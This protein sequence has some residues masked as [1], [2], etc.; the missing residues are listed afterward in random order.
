MKFV[1]NKKQ[2]V[3]ISFLTENSAKQIYS[4]KKKKFNQEDFLTLNVSNYLQ[5]DSILSIIDASQKK[6]IILNIEIYQVEALQ[7][8]KMNPVSNLI[9]IFIHKV[10]DLNQNEELTLKIPEK[11]PYDIV[12]INI[13]SSNF[14]IKIFEQLKKLFKEESLVKNLRNIKINFKN[15]DQAWNFINSCLKYLKEINSISLNLKN[16]KFSRIFF[17]EFTDMLSNFIMLKEIKL[18]LSNNLNLFHLGKETTYSL[19]LNKIEKLKKISIKFKEIPCNMIMNTSLIYLLTLNSSTLEILKLNFNNT[20]FLDQ[21]LHCLVT[22]L[23]KLRKLKTF[24]LSLM[25]NSLGSNGAK[26]LAQ[27]FFNLSQL[28]KLSLNLNSNTFDTTAASFLISSVKTLKN[29]KFLSLDFGRNRSL[30]STFVIRISELNSCLSKNLKFLKIDLSNLEMNPLALK[31]L[32]ISFK[33]LKNLKKLIINLKENRFLED[34]SFSPQNKEK[35]IYQGKSKNSSIINELQENSLLSSSEDEHYNE[36]N[37]KLSSIQK[38]KKNSIFATISATTKNLSYKN[39][40]FKESPTKVQKRVQR[41]QKSDDINHYF[42]KYKI[43]KNLYYFQLDISKNKCDTQG[44]EILT[45]IFEFKFF[46]NLKKLELFLSHNKLNSHNSD[47]FFYELEQL[48]NLNHLNLNLKHNRLQNRGCI[49][50]S[51][52]ISKLTNLTY[53]NLNLKN[54]GISKDGFTTLFSSLAE[55][56]FL[57]FLKINL[58]HN[59]ISKEAVEG[60]SKTFQNLTCLKFFIFYLHFNVLENEGLQTLGRSLS[61]LSS[62]L[63]HLDLNFN[64]NSSEEYDFSKIIV[65]MMHFIDLKYFSLNMND[66]K[67][68][69]IKDFN[70]LKEF[71]NKILK[72]ITVLIL[73]LSKTDAKNEFLNSFFSSLSVTPTKLKRLVLHFNFTSINFDNKFLERFKNI[74][75]ENLQSLSLDFSGCFELN[76]EFGLD[77]ISKILIQTKILE[78]LQILLKGNTFSSESFLFFTL[79]LSNLKYLRILNLDF[80]ASNLTYDSIKKLAKCFE[81]LCNLNEICLDFEDNELK[82]LRSLEEIL[83]SL[84]NCASNL[85]KLKINMNNTFLNHNDQT[86]INF[87]SRLNDL[88]YVKILY[89]DLGVNNLLLDKFFGLLKI[90]SLKLAFLQHFYLNLELNSFGKNQSFIKN[91]EMFKIISDNSPFI[92]YLNIHLNFNE[93]SANK[94]IISEDHTEFLG[95]YPQ[96]NKIKQKSLLK[97]HRRDSLEYNSRRIKM[98]NINNRKIDMTDSENSDNEINSM[99]VDENFQDKLKKEFDVFKSNPMDGKKSLRKFFRTHFFECKRRKNPRKNFSLLLFNSK[100][101]GIALQ[102]CHIK[103]PNIDDIYQTIRNLKPLAIS[104]I[105]F[106]TIRF[107]NVL[108]PEIFN[109]DLS[110]LNNFSKKVLAHFSL[111]F[112][113]AYDQKVW[114]KLSIFSHF[115]IFKLVILDFEITSFHHGRINVFYFTVIFENTFYFFKKANS[116]RLRSRSSSLHFVEEKKSLKSHIMLFIDR[117]LEETPFVSFNFEN[118]FEKSSHLFTLKTLQDLSKN[119]LLFCKFNHQHLSKLISIFKPEDS[120]TSKTVNQIFQNS[121]KTA[122][123]IDLIAFI[124]N[125]PSISQFLKI[126]SFEMLIN[127][128]KKL[129]RNKNI[130]IW[131]IVKWKIDELNLEKNLNICTR[132]CQEGLLNLLDNYWKNYKLD[133]PSDGTKFQMRN[134]DKEINKFYSGLRSDIKDYS[135]QNLD[136]SYQDILISLFEN[137]PNLKKVNLSNLNLNDSF[138]EKFS[139]LLLKDFLIKLDYLNISHNPQ[140]TNVGLKYLAVG[141][142]YHKEKNKRCIEVLVKKAF[143]NLETIIL[144]QGLEKAIKNRFANYFIVN[145]FFCYSCLRVV[146]SYCHSPNIENEGHDCKQRRQFETNIEPL[147]ILRQN[148]RKLEWYF[149]IIKDPYFIIIIVYFLLSFPLHIGKNIVL[150][151]YILFKKFKNFVNR[152]IPKLSSKKSLKICQNYTAIKKIHKLSFFSNWDDIEKKNNAF[153]YDKRVLNVETFLKSNCLLIFISLLQFLNYLICLVSPILFQDVIFTIF[154]SEIFMS[155]IL[156]LAYCHICFIYEILLSSLIIKKLNSNS[157]ELLIKRFNFRNYG[158]RIMQTLA[159]KIGF[160]LDTFFMIILLKSRKLVHIG[161]DEEKTEEYSFKI[162]DIG[163]FIFLV[164]VVVNLTM[165]I[166]CMKQAVVFA[167]TPV[168][169]FKIPGLA[170]MMINFHTRLAVLNDFQCLSKILDRF[171][172]KS[173][174]KLKSIYISQIV[175]SSLLKFLFE[176]VTLIF[177]QIIYLFEVQ[178]NLGYLV[179]L[180]FIFK[181][182]TFYSSFFTAMNAKASNFSREDLEKLFKPSS[183][184]ISKLY[185]NEDEAEFTLTKNRGFT[186]QNE[187]IKK[188]KLLKTNKRKDI[189]KLR[190]INYTQSNKRPSRASKKWISNYDLLWLKGDRK[191]IQNQKSKKINQ[192]SVNPVKE[193]K[194]E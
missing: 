35:N 67:M 84:K 141:L 120:E 97:N 77:S 81:K 15:N 61:K 169:K 12:K 137:L 182:I 60:L 80:S 112:P 136:D 138:C 34:N 4:Q 2:T 116:R 45:K 172:T 101:K 183:K 86:L 166:Y 82:D 128:L 65:N 68:S 159:Y 105:K 102:I 55:I 174:I 22:S 171:S 146:C 40:E 3:P 95:L 107:N 13:Q 123:Q 25:G 36:N 94:N 96:L 157:K 154:D 109:L 189:Q 17:S 31:M 168:S 164:Y 6:K 37:K 151:F 14:K 39:V 119:T 186:F 124:L 74:T 188:T 170:N 162:Y 150:F 142:G 139:D 144:D 8:N 70:V 76:S 108:C 173:A 7:Q 111:D 191:I 48:S 143:K 131:K 43:Y 88:K 57:T 26:Y 121:L 118:F 181:I 190:E 194:N 130:Q 1:R 51:E 193:G 18:D 184:K 41:Q 85:K 180:I 58:S 16:S 56:P 11:I 62:K 115:E 152:K 99:A 158:I 44:L 178:K 161:N 156:I 19:N 175:I 117:V 103:H 185:L 110:F 90:N 47:D 49:F 46:P 92:K 163:V 140:I 187:V 132:T 52:T 145:N 113:P 176:D 135:F 53:L 100:I 155:H 106:L 133:T 129:K 20:N 27:C 66:Q 165:A 54:N 10:S 89:L 104:Q 5:L 33:D 38:R 75:F 153:K 160:Y 98:L 192:I 72:K 126:K 177:S 179:F 24:K 28:E 93:V 63:K 87:F 125:S 50:L 122:L 9:G 42:S 32:L 23:S 149:N 91:Q 59:Y 64:N 73:N 134:F 127:F 78:K 148:R 71:F 30:D 83:M 21:Y 29:L 69:L 147:C 167:N 79:E 114:A